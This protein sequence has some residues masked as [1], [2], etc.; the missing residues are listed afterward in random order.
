MTICHLAYQFDPDAL[1]G[2]MAHWLHL[3]EATRRETL[4][5][6]FALPSV[7]P[8]LEALRV[9][10]DIVAQNTATTYGA[11]LASLGGFKSLPNLTNDGMGPLLDWLKPDK[12]GSLPDH[13]NPARGRKLDD[14]LFAGFSTPH[15]AVGAT[16]PEQA[17]IL[18]PHDIAVL[19]QFLHAPG[20]M[21][22]AD[23]TR[24]AT[25]TMLENLATN[26]TAL[27]VIIDQ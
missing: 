8:I 11:F 24:E 21:H 26:Q 27:L 23:A 3:P 20:S 10:R 4:H 18:L 9:D 13:A 19:Q 7:T 5:G 22:L 1:H 14:A 17:G 6:L 12:T 25:Y 2:G 16:L 15:I